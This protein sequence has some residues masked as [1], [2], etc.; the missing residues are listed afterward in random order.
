M[1]KT[2]SSS[3]AA[4]SGIEVLQN[5]G[6]VELRPVYVVFGEEEFL[7]SAA[8]AAI[9]DC[10]LGKGADDFG[11]GRFDGKTAALADVLDELAMLPFLGPRR[12]V[13]LQNADEFVSAHRDALERY[14]QKPHRTGVLLL[15]VQSWPSNTRLA[16]F[17][18]QGGLAI[19][20]KSPEDRSLA[21]WCRKWAKDRYGKRLA[22]DA[23]D[24][25]VELVGGGLGQLDG[26]LNKLAAYVGERPDISA[27][28]VDQLVAAGRVETVWKI[29]DAATA[30]DAAAALSMLQS[31]TAAGEQ[32]LLIF[33]AISSQL[34][35]L[36][37]AFRL[38]S[39]GE[40]PRSALPRAGVP[41]YFVDKAHAQLR[42]LGRDRL[43]RIYKWLSETD[44][45]MKGDSSLSP[46]HLLERLVVRVACKSEK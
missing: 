44:L 28:D 43:G 37:K 9:R 18:A 30:G 19:D 22:T 31:L 12:L 24:L 33:G 4:V 29:I 42:H 7:R 26:E 46:P 40:P 5:P 32:P 38:M 27:E 41:P 8:T 15:S 36:A 17:V 14:V 16:R 25:L 35:K 45:G 3:V 23:A 21:P 20:C 1:A 6:A 10:V 2:S 11:V 39:A 34:R 13:I